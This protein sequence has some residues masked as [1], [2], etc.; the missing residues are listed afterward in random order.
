MTIENKIEIMIRFLFGL[1]W[2]KLLLSYMEEKY[3]IYSNVIII[4]VMNSPV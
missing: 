2:I 4:S 1:D 3:L